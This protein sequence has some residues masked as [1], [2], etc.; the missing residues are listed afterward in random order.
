M[1]YIFDSTYNTIWPLLILFLVCVLEH[2][3]MN[4]EHVYIAPMDMCQ[5]KV[6]IGKWA[7]HQGKYY[8]F[9]FGG[10]FWL[11]LQHWTGFYITVLYG[12]FQGLFGIFKGSFFH[13]GGKIACGA[14]VYLFPRADVPSVKL[15]KQR[16]KQQ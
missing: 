12:N 10:Y 13:F 5:L 9:I 1:D 15:I 3:W 4:L 16:V 11:N 14:P 7:D 8:T 2:G 6:K